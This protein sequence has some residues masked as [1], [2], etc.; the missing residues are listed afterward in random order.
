ME[1]VARF[2]KGCVRRAN[3]R[4]LWLAVVFALYMS[5]WLWLRYCSAFRHI[6]CA[7]PYACSSCTHMDRAEHAHN[8]KPTMPRG[9]Q[10]HQRAACCMLGFCASLYCKWLTRQSYPLS[11]VRKRAALGSPLTGLLVVLLS[12]SHSVV[13]LAGNW[14]DGAWKHDMHMGRQHGDIQLAH[15]A[16]TCTIL[17]CERYVHAAH[18][19]ATH[20]PMPHLSV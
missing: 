2:E 11:T 13:M 6:H 3:V 1:R 7:C 14:T 12:S 10:W 16:W 9:Q 17:T 8:R 19:I 18:A 15:A 5:M 20:V 4:L